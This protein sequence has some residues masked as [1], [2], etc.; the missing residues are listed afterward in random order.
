MIV[1][2]IV[3]VQKYKPRFVLGRI[4]NQQNKELE[5]LMCGSAVPRTSWME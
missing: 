4:R 3:S 5:Q 2:G 1:S